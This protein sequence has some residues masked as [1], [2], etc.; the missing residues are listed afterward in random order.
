MRKYD[1]LYEGIDEHP[2]LKRISVDQP[3][4][5]IIPIEQYFNVLLECH[6]NAGHG[7]RDKMIFALKNKYNIPRKAIEVFISLCK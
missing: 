7:G 2:V 5:Y 4:I 3:I 6:R 1:I